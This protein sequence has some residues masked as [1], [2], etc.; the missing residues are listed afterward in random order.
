MKRR[1]LMIAYYFPP[2][3]MGGVQRMTK[4][5]KYLPQCGYDGTVL[6]VKPI[7]YPAMDHSLLDDLPET[8]KIIRAGSRDPAR[9]LRFLPF[10][11]PIG[12]RAR[13]V[14]KQKLAWPDS[15]TGWVGPAVKQGRVLLETGDYN[16]LLSS[17]PPISSHLVAMKLKQQFDIP[18]VADF[19]DIWE[20]ETPETLYDDPATISKSRNLLAEIIRLSDGATAVNASVLSDVIGNRHHRDTDRVIGGGYDPDDFVD[21]P[22]RPQTDA[23]NLVYMGTVSEMTS[24]EPFFKAAALLRD[25]GELGSAGLTFTIIGKVQQK[26]IEIAAGRHGLAEAVAFTG[27]MN[28]RDALIEAARADILLLSLDDSLEHVITGKVF[29][30]TGLPAPILAAV[31]EGGEAEWFIQKHNLGLC[32]SGSNPQALAVHLKSLIDFV[33]DNQTWPKLHTETITRQGAA[34]E[35]AALCN[36]IIDG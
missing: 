25:N 30:Y 32:C 14:A 22:E 31:P 6:T 20:M 10:K 12:S 33:R 15:K 3:G 21:L 36:D 7:T 4:L 9:L 5:A 11:I 29:D 24:L 16:I 34:A 35:F 28:H 1:F 8:I 18:W 2:L 13:R 23:I 17:S 26:E 27:Y 19:R